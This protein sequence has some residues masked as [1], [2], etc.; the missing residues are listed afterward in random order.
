MLF[1]TA[2]EVVFCY[3][4]DSA[5]RR[6]AWRALETVLPLIRDGRQAGFMF[7][8]DGHDPDSLVR[9][10]GPSAFN[11]RQAIKPLSEFLL[12]ELAAK[13]NMRSIDGRARFVDLTKPM[14]AK[15]PVGSFRQLLIQRISELA[16]LD[17][18]ALSSSF[19]ADRPGVR[20]VPRRR[21]RQAPSL[22]EKALKPLLLDPK[23]AGLVENRERL[24]QLSD[25]NANFLFEILEFISTQPD[26]TTGAL[27]EHYRD[28][29]FRE[30][31]D[32]MLETPLVLD[33]EAHSLEFQQA[34][35][36]LL[37]KSEP[38]VL[39][40]AQAEQQRRADETT[41]SQE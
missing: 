35:D 16:D 4:G 34:V 29:A 23:L 14:V 25:E 38:T 3:D 7:V 15:I 27:V 6:A 28:S 39:E 19:G 33:V 5:G 26:I 24:S 9:E 11:D 37:R 18:R 22:V 31:L 8:P 32:R 2:P 13:T 10:K 30:L 12:D 21:Q 17:S 40:R 1:K 20:T 41:K 36:A